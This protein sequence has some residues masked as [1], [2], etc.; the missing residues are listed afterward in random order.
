MQIPSFK[1]QLKFLTGVLIMVMTV[2]LEPFEIIDGVTAATNVPQTAAPNLSFNT[3]PALVN[4]TIYAYPRKNISITMTA[5][6]PNGYNAY[7]QAGI[8][9]GQTFYAPGNTA[10][11][12][13]QGASFRNGANNTQAV[14][15]WTPSTKDANTLPNTIIFAAINSYGSGNSNAAGITIKVLD[16]KTPT[17]DPSTP[18]QQTVFVNIPVQIP[19]VV[20]T[21]SDKDKVKILGHTIPGN[22]ILSSAAKNAKGQWVANLAWTPTTTEIG[23][24]NAVFSANDINETS[25]QLY[26]TAFTIADTQVPSFSSAMPTLQKAI[27]NKTLTYHITVYPDGNTNDVLITATGLP[28]GAKLSKPKLNGR[29]IIAAVTWKPQ[30][31]QLNQSYPIAFSAEDNVAGAQLVT[32]DTT[33]TVAAK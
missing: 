6:D 23:L 31:T 30:K 13:P 2:K 17:F 4:N 16:N 1:T 29:K 14:F 7:M 5:T 24:F 19:I 22:S 20:N 26:T 18:S 33:F 8:V 21:D 12:L 10:L 32:F 27:V 11:A 3:S 9:E 28:E 25:K 15:N